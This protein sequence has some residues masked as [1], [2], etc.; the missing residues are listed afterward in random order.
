MLKYCRAAVAEQG[1]VTVER[2]YTHTVFK[3]FYVLVKRCLC[4]DRAFSLERVSVLFNNA[5]KRVRAL[6]KHGRGRRNQYFAYLLRSSLR[7]SFKIGYAVN[8]F[9]PQLNS[10]G[11]FLRR[12]KNIYQ[13]A[14]DGKL[15]LTLNQLTAHVARGYEVVCYHIG[16]DFTAHA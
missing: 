6:V 10:H 7:I 2:F 15:T 11:V 5:D 9:A 13:T 3:L 8:R 1:Q 12:W 4:L 16:Q 14:A